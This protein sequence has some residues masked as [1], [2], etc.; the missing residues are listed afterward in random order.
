MCDTMCGELLAEMDK[1]VEADTLR[2]Q[3]PKE[4]RERTN[5]RAQH[6]MIVS[7]PLAFSST[8]GGAEST[9]AHRAA[10]KLANYADMWEAAQ[11]S[12]HALCY[13]HLILT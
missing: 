7:S 4:V 12:V 10:A 8:E 3:D 6:Y 5:I 11:R 13:P 9:A 1:W 2:R